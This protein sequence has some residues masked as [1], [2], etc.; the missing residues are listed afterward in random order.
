LGLAFFVSR[1]VGARPSDKF[2]EALFAVFVH[3]GAE[4]PIL[5]P[6]DLIGGKPESS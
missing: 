5:R 3:A 4:R 6:Q 2:R 1:D